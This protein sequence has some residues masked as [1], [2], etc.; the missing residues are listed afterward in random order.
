M[1]CWISFYR[2]QIFFFNRKAKNICPF[3]SVCGTAAHVVS[4]S[5]LQSYPDLCYFLFFLSLRHAEEKVTNT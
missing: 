5:V 2:R 4:G 3:G 1:V